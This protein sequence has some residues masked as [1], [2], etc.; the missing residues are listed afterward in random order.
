[1]RPV[2]AKA[3]GDP[4][5]DVHA[6]GQPLAVG[7]DPEHGDEVDDR[8]VQIEILDLDR[9][10]VGL[11]FRE[12]ENAFDQGQQG[13]A[14]SLDGSDHLPLVAVELCAAEQVA[15][16]DDG[17]E[18]CA[19]LV[20][21]AGKEAVLCLV[22]LF[23]LC[24]GDGEFLD[25]RPGIARDRDKGDQQ[26]DPE[27]NATGPPVVRRQ[28]GQEAERRH[29]HGGPEIPD[30]VTE[31]VS[32]GD[33][34]IDGVERRRVLVAQ[35]QDREHGPEIGHHGDE[36]AWTGFARKQ[37]DEDDI[38]EGQREIDDRRQ[39]EPGLLHRSQNRVGQFDHRE[40][41]KQKRH[42]HDA[43][44]RLLVLAVRAIEKPFP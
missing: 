10:L 16:S 23:G 1:M 36:A 7:L 17:V 19:Q 35:G 25:Q 29:G 12:I 9:D 33:P 2:A 44:Q 20:A 4:R 15:H 18:R 26:A 21:H 22:G 37:E 43:H 30:A 41:D 13:L 11:D 31:T 14:R 34:K 28:D 42:D 32:E 39:D 8:G 24:L 6:E 38:G 40:V 3:I 5:R 27:G